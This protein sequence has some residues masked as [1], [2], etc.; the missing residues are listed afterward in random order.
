MS[1]G[2]F[3][4]A[5]DLIDDWRDSVLSGTRP[6]LYPVGDGELARLEI[7]PGLVSLFG[8]APGAGKTAL[9]LQLVVEALQR[10]ADLRALIC[11]VEMPPPVL[12]DRQLA[13]LA[14]IDAGAIRHRRLD[15]EHAE[16]VERGMEALER[17]ADRLA[18]VRPPFNL[19]N[20]AESADASDASLIVIDYIQRVGAP[21]DH[22]DR[23]GTVDA[24]MGYL[25]Q[26]ADAGVAL[27][28]VSAVGRSKDSKGRSSYGEGL[29]LASFR[30]SS[31][32]EFGA[33]DAFILAPDDGEVAP[34]GRVILKH[35]KSRY[36][37]ARDIALTFDRR[38]QRFTP[39]EPSGQPPTES[40]MLQAALRAAWHRARPAEEGE[41]W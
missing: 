11:N 15:A 39:I 6:T 12:L 34:T 10:T 16:A 4:A 3:Q 17:I 19:A 28:V 30:E 41:Q 9:V 5:S 7:G 33:D 27:L 40:G 26:F 35:L 20:V 38:Q 37:E 32:L 8:G 29:N 2:R 23:R 31:E 14:G 22:G 25:R 36:G 21:G 13:R 24:T 1:A 18:F